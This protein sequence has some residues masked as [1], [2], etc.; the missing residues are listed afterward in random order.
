MREKRQLKVFIETYRKRRKIL[1]KMFL[2]GRGRSN[3]YTFGRK[4]QK[5]TVTLCGKFVKSDWKWTE[6]DPQPVLRERTSRKSIFRPEL[7]K[8]RF[9]L[10]RLLSWPINVRPTNKVK[11]VRSRKS[12]PS[13][14]SK[15]KFR[16][17][18]R[19]ASWKK[20]QLHISETPAAHKPGPKCV[21]H[22]SHSAFIYCAKFLLVFSFF[23]FASL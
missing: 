3:F 18:L 22:N 7:N 20:T 16:S 23:L 12:F 4:M 2:V 9:D 13:F 8:M 19:I 14:K 15:S 6:S 21:Q 11:L 5:F 10:W 17:D 1:K